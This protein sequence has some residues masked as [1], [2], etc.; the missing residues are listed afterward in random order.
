MLDVLGWDVEPPDLPEL[1]LV[2]VGLPAVATVRATSASAPVEVQVPAFRYEG[3]AQQRA[4]VFAYDYM[5]LDRIGATLRPARGDLRRLAEPTPVDSRVVDGTYVV[6][7]RDRAVMFTAVTDERGASA[8]HATV[9]Q[10]V[11]AG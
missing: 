4:T 3:R 6:T 8:R 1:A 7:W 9:R 2:G 11:A 5:L 10:A